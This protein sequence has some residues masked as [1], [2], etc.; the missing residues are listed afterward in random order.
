MNKIQTPRYNN[1]TIIKHQDTIYK[2]IPIINKQ[3][4]NFGYWPLFVSC[5]LIIGYLTMGCGKKEEQ[6]KTIREEVI[7]VKTMK[8][9]LENI[10]KTLDYVDDIQAQD[11]AQVFPKVNGKIIEKIKDD[12]NKVNKGDVI[13]YID[14]DEVGLKFEKAP[15]ESPLSGIIGRVYVDIGTSVTPQTA[16]ALVV[17]IDK[18]KIDL[19]IPEKYI[20]QISIGEEALINVDAYPEEKFKGEVSTI[21]PVIDLSTR[22]APIEI[23]INNTDHRLKPGMFARVQLIIKKQKNIPVIVK[24]AII[25]RGEYLY[26]YVIEN[27]KASLRKI[28]TGIRQGN[29]FEVTEGLK[30]GDIVVIMGQQKLYDGAEVLLEQN[31]Q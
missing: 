9:E 26:V 18:V 20:P 3:L 1:Q 5:I 11:E 10:Q 24:E 29:Y 17:N 14:R 31:G 15:V 25:G 16:V 22:T 12:G 7:P 30:E 27:N 21:S 6:K 28:T 8:V 2:Q 19:D 13:A 4:L 23:I